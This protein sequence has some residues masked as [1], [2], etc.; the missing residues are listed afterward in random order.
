MGRPPI[1]S[2]AMTKTEL[3]RRWRAGRKAAAEDALFERLKATR[4]LRISSNH[5]MDVRGLDPYF[6]G[7]EAVVCLMALERAYLPKVI[8]DPCAG[9]GAFTTLMAAHGY[10]THANDIFDYGLPVC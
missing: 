3:Q 5:G 8:L 7:P 6:T 9:D 10:E 2:V 1:H 4:K